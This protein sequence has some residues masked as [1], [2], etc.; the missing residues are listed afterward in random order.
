MSL[1]CR[2]TST[3]FKRI[4]KNT[5]QLSLIP[6]TSLLDCESHCLPT[7]LPLSSPLNPHLAPNDTLISISHSGFAITSADEMY[8]T[9][10]ENVEDVLDVKVRLERSDSYTSSVAVA[11]IY[12]LHLYNWYPF[13]ARSD[14]YPH[15]S[16]TLRWTNSLL[17]TGII[18]RWVQ[19]RSE[20]TG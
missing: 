1:I 19:V 8:H 4:S 13:R 6:P 7:T 14:S 18:S 5:Y 12:R 9:V 16:S 11:Y 2:I 10:W 17:K 20:A 15:C 3:S